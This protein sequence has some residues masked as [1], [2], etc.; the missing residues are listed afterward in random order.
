MRLTLRLGLAVICVF[1]ACGALLA[2]AAMAN[3]AFTPRFAQMARG[4]VTLAANTI[5]TC[6]SS[7]ACTSGRA[8][9]GGSINNQDFVMTY[10]DVDSD[11]TTFDSSSANLTLPSGSTVLF[12]G[13]YWGA[14]TTAG[15]SGAAAPSPAA[16]N[17]VKL[18]VPG[19]ATYSNVTASVLDTD[20][21]STSRYQGFANVTSQ[22]QAAGVGTYTVANVQA[23]TGTD[24]Y[25]GWSLV[26]AY[27]DSAEEVNWVSV[28]DGFESTGFGGSASSTDVVLNGF[29]TPASGTVAARFGMVSYEG[30]LGWTGE[31]ATLNGATLTDA[32]HPAG[33]YFNST[34][35][36]LGSHVTTKNPNYVNQLGFD[37]NVMNVDGMLPSGSTSATVHFTSSLDMF[38]PGVMTL[39]TDQVATGPANTSPPSAG[40]T[41]MDGQ[42]LTAGDGTWSGSTPM[43]FAYQWRRC[44]S[45]GASC[46][47]IAGATGSTYQLVSSDVG[48]TFR[49][50]VTATNAVASTS[51]TS[52]A[53]AVAAP[54]PPAG[55]SPPTVSG[56]ARDG[57]TLSATT[58][59]WTGTPSI[60]YAYQWQR[61]DSLGANCTNVGGATGSTYVL[62]P[63]DVGSTM[64]AVVTATN[65]A[66]S[67]SQTSSQT[68]VVAATPPV[69]TGAPTVS[70]TARDGQTLT[71]AAGSWTGTPTIS[72]A[73]QWQRCDSLG[74]S[75]ANV[76][77]ANASTFVLGPADVGSTMRAVVTATNAGGSAPATSSQ[78]AVVAANPPV[79][80]GALPAISGQPYDGQPLAGTTGSWTGS[81]TISYAYQWQRCDSSGSGC[82]DI[83]GATGASYDLTAADL[84][85]TIRLA[86]TATNGAGAVTSTSAASAVITSAEPATSGGGPSTSGTPQE[87]G[88]L[89]VDP[90]TWTG[91]APITFEYQWLRC[92]A[93]G[94][95]CV[96]IPGATG[97][98]YQP[99]AAD[100]GHTIVVVVTATNGAGSTTWQSPPSDVITVAPPR[101]TSSPSIT[102][103]VLVGE[104]LTAHPGA[105]TGAG[106]IS[107]DY[108]WLRCDAA[109]KNCQQIQGA[110]GST[111]VVTAADAG[112][113][114]RVEVSAAN[115]GGSTT[116]RSNDTAAVP[117]KDGGGNGGGGD[118]DLGTT[119][120]DSQV[121]PSKCQRVLAGTGFKRQ[122]MTGVGKISMQVAA[123]AYISPK[124]PLKVT[125]KVP[126][127]KVRSLQYLLDNRVVSRPKR[128]PYAL[129]V[130]PKVFGK[131]GKHALAFR[132]TPKKGR[133]HRMTLQITT[134]PCDNVLS[135]FQFKT[136]TGTGL[137]LRVD[138]RTAMG[139]AAFTVPAKMLPSL[140]DV[141]KI[142]TLSIYLPGRRTPFE[143]R[144]AKGDRSATLL[145]P[146]ARRPRVVLTKKRVIVT[147]LPKRVGIVELTLYTRDKTK[148][149]AFLPKRRKVKIAAM[150]VEGGKTVRLKSI[151]TAQRH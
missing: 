8:G 11:A 44:N 87:N 124:K 108:Q 86:V 47:D 46:V 90:G 38:L 22:V 81:P 69:N 53:T 28:Y 135:G 5:M 13:L 60:S 127:K 57:Q 67:A 29:Q 134:A 80:D 139:S 33:N 40:G 72:Y 144:L 146:T 93:A 110:T 56:T 2:P 19:G 10:V 55:T 101:S 96:E 91:S 118:E 113:T 130:S 23:G 95:N 89:T 79:N 120:P 125:A 66:G 142:G 41:V 149:D 150:V 75:C 30:E 105:W 111:Y 73:Y 49:V 123:S 129:K 45:S 65:A 63:A 50:V 99:T 1:A 106:P 48:S 27:L 77:G 148:P 112:H 133:S 85:S 140:K 36:R 104:T 136:E 71:A 25:G 107:Y 100:A 34:I 143:L 14:D 16:R 37:A 102:G 31:T 52:P 58:G 116:K 18:K 151:I 92:D 126:A 43:T 32:L 59:A 145:R 131:P 117:P 88:T 51:A 61:C 122:R 128:A 15:G 147:G 68:A 6:P 7:A 39:V 132:V 17:T 54:A 83:A 64:R 3:R 98:S 103:D 119:I 4:D 62:G 35:S 109:G 70:G 141:G 137:R 121:N 76:G 9:T 20:S 12:A 138:S 78:T 97:A 84:G 21:A 115:G 82:S 114:F 24:R 94:Q 74:A 26:V 42:T